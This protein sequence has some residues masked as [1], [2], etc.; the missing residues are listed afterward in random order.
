VVIEQPVSKARIDE[1]T[2]SFDTAQFSRELTDR[3]CIIIGSPDVSDF[4]EVTL[5]SLLGVPPYYPG[6]RLTTGFRIRKAG[7]RFST[8][9]EE[10]SAGEPDGVRVIREDKSENLFACENDRDHGVMILA[11]NPFSRSG[12]KHKIL[13]LAG[14]S[15]I[16][17]RAMSLLLTHEEPWCL[18]AFFDLDQEIAMMGSPL[19]A[20]IEVSYKRTPGHDGIGDERVI[21]TEHN[22]IRVRDA[23]VLK[24]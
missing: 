13:I 20:V 12:Q 9:Y 4:A 18:D 6:A 1:H 3:N 17:T 14:H 21:S 23:I 22:S 7:R 16:A 19:A 15:G 8:F 2:R 24:A 11:D 5:A 10:S